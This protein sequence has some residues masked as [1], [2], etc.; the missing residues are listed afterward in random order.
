VYLFY[1]TYKVVVRHYKK[2]KQNDKKVK[3]EKTIN[4]LKYSKNNNIL[5]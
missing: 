4:R 5:K 1:G 3:M 2:P